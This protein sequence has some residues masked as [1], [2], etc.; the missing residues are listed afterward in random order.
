MSGD[1]AVSWFTQLRTLT[2]SD[3]VS[4]VSTYWRVRKTG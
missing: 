3:E 2:G 1:L 4:N